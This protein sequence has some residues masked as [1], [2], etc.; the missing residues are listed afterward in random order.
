MVITITDVDY[1]PGDLYD[2]APIVVELLKEMPGDDRPDYWLAVP[3]TPIKWASESNEREITHIVIATRWA[4]M[5][6]DAD[7]GYTPIGIAYVLDMSIIEDET[8]DFGK[9]RYVAI[10]LATDTTNR[11]LPRM[12]EHIRKGYTTRL[13]GVG[14]S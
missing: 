5:H 13:F 11:E 9:V 6:V 2:Q 7:M 1:A 14:E 3:K 8:L 10:G 4:G 12:S